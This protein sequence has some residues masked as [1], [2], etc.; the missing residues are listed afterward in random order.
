MLK[1]KSSAIL[2]KFDKEFD[3]IV[4]K[5]GHFNEFY[6]TKSDSRSIVSIVIEEDY[7][8]FLQA[9]EQYN[10]TTLDNEFECVEITFMP[11]EDDEV[12]GDLPRIIQSKIILIKEE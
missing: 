8:T 9:L 12:F 6:V 3:A 1:E 4:D 11:S 2:E 10:K 7:H 5:R